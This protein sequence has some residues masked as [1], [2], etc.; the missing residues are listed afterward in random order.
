MSGENVSK[1][2]WQQKIRGLVEGTQKHGPSGSF[3]LGSRVCTGAEMTQVLESMAAA[4]DA[5]DAAKAAWQDALA[6]FDEIK[7]QVAPVIQGYQAWVAVT[8]AGTP[9]TLADYG[10]APRKT[11]TPLT[12][13]QKKLAVQRRLATRAARHTMGPKQKQKGTLGPAGTIVEPT[14]HA[15]ATP[16]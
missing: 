9:S 6:R 2:E 5:V 10:V 3:T 1:G 13:E 4:I 7:A 15:P 8:H 12:A 14:S 11:P 16:D